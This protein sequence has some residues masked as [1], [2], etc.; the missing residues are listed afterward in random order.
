MGCCWHVQTAAPGV[1]E[2]H[3]GVTAVAGTAVV[4]GGGGVRLK[5]ADGVV[6]VTV[7]EDIGGPELAEKVT[8]A[9]A[10]LSGERPG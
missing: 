4:C 3:L 2:S 10:L 9:V 1:Y 5:F 8:N 6:W 7:G